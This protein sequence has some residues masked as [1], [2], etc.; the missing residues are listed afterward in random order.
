M[1]K[2]IGSSSSND[3]VI[4]DDITVSRNHAVLFQDSLGH[5]Y[6]SNSTNG[7]FVNGVR[8]AEQRKLNKQD[9][10]I[11]GKTPI[12]W[13]SY[14]DY[15]ST[16]S[17]VHLISS[18][19]LF[20]SSLF[21]LVNG[22]TDPDHSSNSTINF[23]HGNLFPVIMLFFVACIFLIVLNVLNFLRRNESI[24]FIN[25]LYVSFYILAIINFFYILIR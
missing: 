3:I 20:L 22:L 10:L 15:K 25:I 14:F 16:S 9:I 6:I 17:Y 1:Q 11:V 7:T 4:S 2:T 8:L 5:I 18:M 23:V 19:L 24:S 13:I 21:F 12:D